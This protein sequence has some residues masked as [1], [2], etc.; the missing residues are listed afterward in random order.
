MGTKSRAVGFQVRL[1]LDS[2]G[3][4]TGSE[5][6]K[7]KA[8]CGGV[9]LDGDI[10]SGQDSQGWTSAPA[11]GAVWL[12][13]VVNGKGEFVSADLQSSGGESSPLDLDVEEDERENGTYYFHLADIS[14]KE[15]RQHIAGAVYLLPKL[16]APGGGSVSLTAGKGISLTE[17][18]AED[19]GGTRIDALLKDCV[20]TEDTESTDPISLIGCDT[21]GPNDGE[22]WP[23]KMLCTSTGSQN[24]LKLVDLGEKIMFHVP[25][26]QAG[27][28]LKYRTDSSSGEETSTLD[29]KVTSSATIETGKAPLTLLADTKG[30]YGYVPYASSWTALLADSNT[31]LRLMVTS[32]GGLLYIQQ[33]QYSNGAYSAIN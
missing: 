3:A 25:K 14:G 15:V 18:T 20:Q 30:L 21:A 31:A 24:M 11:S 16:H 27:Y 23:L 4:V 2:D 17:E 8:F 12:C 19:G 7:G 13:V 1:Q 32:P 9:E 6:F 22:A 33:G 26:I 28:G 10:P 29:V 5:V